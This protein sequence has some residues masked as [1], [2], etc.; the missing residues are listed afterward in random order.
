MLSVAALSLCKFWHCSFFFSS[1]LIDIN[2]GLF[3]VSSNFLRFFT[4]PTWSSPR[5]TSPIFQEYSL[6]FF[7]VFCTPLQVIGTFGL[8]DAIHNDTLHSVSSC[9]FLI[10]FSFSLFSMLSSTFLLTSSFLTI[11]SQLAPS[12]LG[13]VISCIFFLLLCC[14]LLSLFDFFQIFFQ[15]FNL[16]VNFL[17]T[18]SSSLF[19]LSSIFSFL[20]YKFSWFSWRWQPFCYRFDNT[21]ASC[22]VISFLNHS[23]F[24][25]IQLWLCFNI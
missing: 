11:S 8:F 22:R 4:F 17:L 13:D 25:C 21:N 12:G 3:L 10:F 14:L 23:W 2:I 19:T 24:N 1:V 6:N 9:S 7:Y 18:S 20:I 5:S 15:L 16:F